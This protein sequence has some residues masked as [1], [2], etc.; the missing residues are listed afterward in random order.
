MDEYREETYGQRIAEV[1][2]QWYAGYDEAAVALLAE[3]AR[4]GLALELGI[5]TGRV[6]L[7]L[8]QAGVAVH[9]LD[10]SEA[11][12][13]R[14]RAKPGGADVPVTLGNFAHV[15]VQERFALIYVMFNTLFALLTQ[16]EQVRCFRNVAEHLLPDGVFVVEAFVPDLSRFTGNQ[17]IRTVRMDQN[18]VHVDASVHDPVN[19]LVSSQHIALSE[20][21]VRLY[22]V[23]LRYA[24]PSELD[25][26]AQLAGL[27]LRARWGNWQQDAFSAASGKHISV[28]ERER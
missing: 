16:A 12:V 22:P 26:M 9:G 13:A 15:A 18:S 27:R 20:Q 10:A 5:G 6:A 23:T 1:Y 7:P 28:Y 17:A 21:G 24:W 3:L 11:M 2:D 8:R 25:L 4:G 19:Q 14:L